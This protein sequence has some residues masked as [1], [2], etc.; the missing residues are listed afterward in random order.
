MK[1]S[2]ESVF[3]ASDFHLGVPNHSASLV[4]EKKVVHWIGETLPRARAYYLLGDLFDFW[5][6]YKR[7]VPKGFVRLLGKLAEI[8]DRGAE[9]HIFTGNHDLWMQDYFQ[10][11]IGAQVHTGPHQTEI[12]GKRFYL[13]HGDGIGPGDHGYKKMK[14]IFTHPA[15]Q[16][17]YRWLHPDIGIPLADYFSGKSREANLEEPDETIDPPSEAQVIHSMQVLKSEHFD[18]FIYGHRHIPYQYAVN[19]RSTVYNLGDWMRHF[20]YAEFADGALKLKKHHG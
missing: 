18:Y 3:F 6:E 15:A 16:F 8:A 2:P 12:N 19:D 13:A 1:S 10:K 7:A 20:T 17:L 4:R 14:K 11:E 5:F 9:L